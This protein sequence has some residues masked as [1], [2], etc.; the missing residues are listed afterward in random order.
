MLL[1]PFLLLLSS[2]LLIINKLT[3]KK[4]KLPPSP[5]KLP[6]LGNLHQL[7]AF[8]HR[9][10][11]ELSK[12]YGP[13]MLLR[14]G[15]TPTIVVSS[16]E[17][18]KEILKTH[19]LECCSRPPLTGPKRLSYNFQDIGFVP[20]G[21]YYREVRKICITELFSMKKVQYFQSVRKE[22]VDLLIKSISESATLAS[23][24]QSISAK[25]S[26]HSPLA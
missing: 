12:K 1:I 15:S 9:S 21:N 7:G 2:L 5:P 24:I 17:T 14:L 4:G 13:I 25:E 20:Y 23:R 10:T 26:F 8:P 11:W 3:T 22:E 6:L 16:A 19:D 18:A